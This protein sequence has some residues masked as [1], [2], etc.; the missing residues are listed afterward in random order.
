M[1]QYGIR[2]MIL[3]HGKQVLLLLVNFMLNQV[4]QKE[5]LKEWKTSLQLDKYFDIRKQ[6]EIFPNLSVS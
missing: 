3:L 1:P 4:I 2:K 5:L 6:S